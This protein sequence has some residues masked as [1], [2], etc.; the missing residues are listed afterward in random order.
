MN[1]SRNLRPVTLREVAGLDNSL[2]TL[3]SDD[4]EKLERRTGR[5]CLTLFP[6]ANR[7][8]G[9]VQVVREHRLTEMQL[10]TQTFNVSRTEL[11]H[12]R[13]T[14]RVKLTHGYLAD[15]TSITQCRQVT[16]K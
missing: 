14:N 9:G 7:R 6:L 15:R 16:T 12:G 11:P 4:V 2:Q 5:A 13:W 3:I 1:D 10:L 8:R